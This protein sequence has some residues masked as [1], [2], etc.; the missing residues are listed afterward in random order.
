MSDLGARLVVKRN[1][2]VHT[3]SGREVGHMFQVDRETWEA[4]CTVDGCG[5]ARDERYQR[6]GVRELHL[7]HLSKHRTS[8]SET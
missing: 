3:V 1:H 4:T 7:H 8:G 6:D 2:D 5:W